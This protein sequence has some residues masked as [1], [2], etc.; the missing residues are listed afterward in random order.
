MSIS[1][2]AVEDDGVVGAED[3]VNGVVVT[4]VLAGVLIEG[5]K[6]LTRDAVDAATIAREKN[7]T[8][9]NCFSLS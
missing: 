3:A 7:R 6:A 4:A 8:I 1:H 5:A 2:R 9:V